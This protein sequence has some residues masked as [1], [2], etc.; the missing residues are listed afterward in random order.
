MLHSL[1]SRLPALPPYMRRDDPLVRRELDALPNFLGEDGRLRGKIILLALVGLGIMPCSC[2]CGGVPWTLLA[3]ALNLLPLVWGAGTLNR[4][5]AAD[6]W[7]TLRVTPYSVQEIVLAKLSAVTYR[8]SPLLALLLT[9]ELLS[10]IVSGGMYAITYGSVSV[11]LYANGD[12]LAQNPDPAL[13]MIALIIFGMMLLITLIGVALTFFT[14]IVLGGLASALTKGRGSAAV[15]G[16]G[17][18]AFL[19]ML[20]TLV[21]LLLGL[22]LISQLGNVLGLSTLAALNQ[23][24][25]WLVLLNPAAAFGPLLVTGLMLLVQAGALVGL[26]KLTVIRAR[27]A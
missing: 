5:R 6:T 14:N 10:Y 22:L 23:S 26:F 16:I 4:E 21:N 7:G 20:L 19:T 12:R 3:F 27:A 13:P 18:R 1:L 25:S 2:G 11:N 17:L 9:G 8:L 15:L 24:I